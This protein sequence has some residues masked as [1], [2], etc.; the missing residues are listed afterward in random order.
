LFRWNKNF[1][2]ISGYTPEE[3]QQLNASDL[4]AEGDRN[5]AAAF[6][7]RSQRESTTVTELL[8]L[9]RQ[10]VAIP[11]YFN[12]I[13]MPVENKTCVVVMGF[14]IRDR[15]EREEKLRIS[16]E[17][18]EYVSKA[19]FDAI[20]DWDI[21]NK[22][23]FWGENFEKYFGYD[24]SLSRANLD[25]WNNSIHPDDYVRVTATLDKVIAGAEN[26][27]ADEYRFKRLDGEYAYVQD[28]GFAIRNREGKA[29]RMIGAMHDVTE[30]KKD[31]EKVKRLNNELAEK[32]YA[33]SSSNNELEKFAYVASHDLQEP[34]R[35]ISSFLQLLQ[36][37][38]EDRLDE[39]AEKYIHFAVDGA[40]RMKTLI[41][42]LLEYS[43]V[44]TARDDT[45]NTDMNE[46]MRE[47]REIF[48]ITLEETGAIIKCDN[49]PILPGTRK[50]LMIQLM[51][52]LVGNAIKYHG[53]E[54][55]LIKINAIKAENHWL[56]SVT[57]NGIGIDPAFSEKIFVIFQRLH[58][59]DEF[60]GTGIGLSICKKIVEMH[61]GRIWVEE[62]KAGGSIFYFTISTAV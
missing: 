18:F 12:A 46:V 15:K 48:I 37:K 47:V 26:I 19:T 3:I 33:L 22:E 9:T 57:D 11:F 60:S 38:Y 53:K 13:S 23:L 5:K 7:A 41:N 8:F 45:G 55:P 42:D 1:E 20:W 6:F 58:N 34:L 39:T 27:W 44:S 28:K 30:Q 61:G 40:N 16:N 62:N 17:R 4:F 21:E 56:F 31:E 14:D 51:Q 29:I 2:I 54:K 25:T 24:S 35:M 32:A 10:Q 43:R 50:I 59:K 36:R 49:L 52:N